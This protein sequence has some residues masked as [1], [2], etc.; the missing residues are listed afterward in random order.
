MLL[1]PKFVL[2]EFFMHVQFPPQVSSDSIRSTRDQPQSRL[3]TPSPGVL[4]LPPGAVKKT[5]RDKKK[6]STDYSSGGL[7]PLENLF[8][9]NAA[10]CVET[11]ARNSEG[12]RISYEEE[13]SG[14]D[15]LQQTL[16]RKQ[17]IVQ[18]LQQAVQDFKREKDELVLTHVRNLAKKCH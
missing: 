14:T 2:P 18:G 9:Q 7:F 11:E 15:D 13:N 10:H 17:A 8:L 12:S 5:G 16:M 1:Q 3:P 4:T 6:Q